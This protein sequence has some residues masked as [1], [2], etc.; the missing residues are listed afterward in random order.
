MGLIYAG[1]TD[2]GRK[3]K[4]NQDSIYSSIEERLFIVADGMGGHNGGDIA[5]Q[6]ACNLIPSHMRQAPH[7]TPE[8]NLKE[9][10]NHAHK[11]IH[12]KS[13]C[14]PNLQ[15]MGTT[16]VGAHFKGSDLYIGN[17]G[18]SRCYLINNGLLYQM[19]KD[20]SLVQEKINHGVL[21]RQQAAEDPQKNV[22][23]RSVGFTEE[24]DIDLLSYKVNRHDLFLLCSDGLYGKVSEAEILSITNKAVGPILSASHHSLENAVT[25][26]VAKANQNGGNDNISVILILAQ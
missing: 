23:T 1:L 24:L 13:K 17:V 7:G 15:G 9:A 14:D 5:G 10:I 16:V 21:T 20:H 3:R 19:T 8:K 25:Q 12:E 26:L 4:T 2:I 22:L 6:M 11:K 18:D